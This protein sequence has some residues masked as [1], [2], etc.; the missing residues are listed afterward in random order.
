MISLNHFYIDTDYLIVNHEHVC[1]LITDSYD[2][3][4]FIE[5]PHSEIRFRN[6]LIP[7]DNIDDTFEYKNGIPVVIGM[8]RFGNHSSPSVEFTLADDYFMVPYEAVK[9]IRDVSD[10]SEYEPLEKFASLERFAS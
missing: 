5:V 10:F 4:Y 3:S 7:F 1:K 2:D 6:V 8:D 9:L